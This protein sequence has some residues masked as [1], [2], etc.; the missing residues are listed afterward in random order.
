MGTNGMSLPSVWLACM[1]LALGALAGT[2]SAQGYYEGETLEIIVP[3]SPGGGTDTW[4]RL[5]APHLQRQLG[6]GASV[7]VV[8]VPGAGSVAGAN[9]FALRREPDGLTAF[10][11]GGSTVM[12]YVTREP[13][14]QYE[15][16]DFEAIVGSALG[17]VVYVRPELGISTAP[18]LLDPPEP[19]VYGGISATGLDM[20]PL[21]IFESLDLGIQV[22]MGYEGRGPARIAFERG[23]TNI[24]YSTA[25]AYLANVVPLVEEGDAVPLFTFGFIDEDGNVARDPV[26]PDLPSAREAHVEV[27]GSE[28][29]GEAWEVYSALLG[30]MQTEKMLWIHGDAPSEAADELRAASQRMLE[31]PEFI[32]AARDIV[33]DYPFVVGD[34]AA[35]RFGAVTAISDESVEW[36]LDFLREHYD[37]ER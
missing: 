7:Q 16:A 31:D 30:A 27:H 5:V 26:F 6:E 29:A 19:L 23:E 25:S 33:G 35:Q 22:I 17:G 12:H 18:E 20:L 9:E 28:P 37:V 3:F 2:V 15:F 36:V 34:A 21:L 14:V 13:A 1:A 10:V 24:D 11:H 4:A 8:N 32:E